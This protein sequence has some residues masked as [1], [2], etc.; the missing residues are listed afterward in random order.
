MEDIGINWQPPLR[1]VQMAVPQWQISD[2]TMQ[3]M[4]ILFVLGILFCWCKNVTISNTKYMRG[5]NIL[6]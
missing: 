4:A 1:G 2:T 3:Y 6:I 5:R